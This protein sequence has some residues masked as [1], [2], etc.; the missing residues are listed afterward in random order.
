MLT[1]GAGRKKSGLHQFGSLTGA[2]LSPAPFD[3]HAGRCEQRPYQ[4]E[5]EP[6]FF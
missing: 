5:F 4:H 3:I 2:E 1:P 6:D